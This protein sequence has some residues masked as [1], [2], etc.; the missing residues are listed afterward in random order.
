MGQYLGLEDSYAHL[1]VTDPINIKTWEIGNELAAKWE[2]H[3]SWLA[4]GG[5]Q[6]IYYQTGVTPTLMF[7]P[8]TDSLHYFG[9]ILWRAGWV[10]EAGD[11]MDKMS[12][13]LGATHVVNF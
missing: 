4:G 10:P 3:V 2:W 11:G 9:G 7:R 1:G 12:S 13:I 8:L 5:H 6:Q